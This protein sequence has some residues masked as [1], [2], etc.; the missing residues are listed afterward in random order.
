MTGLLAPHWPAFTDD[1][2][3]AVLS[4]YPGAGE[5]RG[6]LLTSQR[7]ISTAGLVRTDVRDLFVKRHHRR[8]RTV[9]QLE[10][11]HRFADHVRARGVPAPALLRTRSGATAVDYSGWT[12][13]VQHPAVG[14]DRYRTT[15][16]WSPFHAIEDARG[17]GRAL[18]RLHAASTDYDAPP[19]TPQPMRSQL[20]VFAAEDPLAAFE[21][22]FAERP[23]IGAFLERRPWHRE[24]EPHLRFHE[25]LLPL[26]DGLPPWWTHNDWQASNLFWAGND[27][28]SVVDFQLADRTLRIYDVAVALER[29]TIQWL[30]ILA[31]HEHGAV[32]VDHIRAI[33]DGYESILPLSPH[34]RR[35]LVEL[36]PIAQAEFAL[37]ELDYFASVQESEANATWAYET[38]FL[39]HVRWFAGPSG[40]ALLDTLRREL[41]VGRLATASPNGSHIPRSS[42]SH[43]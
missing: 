3:S 43:E 1:E 5:F 33:V 26:L 11:E 8:A 31:G 39:A 13:E 15:H 18:G 25:Q 42:R 17:A 14:D 10:E 24:I 22:L 23:A 29:N 37:S 12:Y 6:R 4:L 41:D 28:T 9:A 16:S 35:A 34:E 27:V 36:L 40:Q 32:H 20:R 38:Y 21:R 2:L 19:R 30:D 7:P